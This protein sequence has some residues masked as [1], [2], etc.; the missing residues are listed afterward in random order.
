MFNFLSIAK[1]EKLK[2][3]LKFQKYF[4]IV[5]LSSISSCTK[6]SQNRAFP[7]FATKYV[8]TIQ[9]YSIKQNGEFYDQKLN[10][11]LKTHRI[12]EEN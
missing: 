8:N 1:L 2:F 4:G 6:T 7:C 9:L 11:E 10:S 5:V 3:S 12:R